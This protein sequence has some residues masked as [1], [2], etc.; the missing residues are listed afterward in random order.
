[1]FIPEMLRSDPNKI[2]SILDEMKIRQD[3]SYNASRSDLLPQP[4]S[5]IPIED[6]HLLNEAFENFTPGEYVGYE[7]DDPSM[8]QKEGDATFIYA[9]IIEEVN[10]EEN[11]TLFGKFFKINVGHDK[12]PRVVEFADLYKFHRLQSSSLGLS[13]EQETATQARD[14][15]KIFAE[16]SDV[17]EE[18]WRLPEERRRKIVKRLFLRWHPDKNLGDETFCTEAFQHIQNEITR[19]ER[20]ETR[21]G[22]PEN[23]RSSFETF[24]NHW[25]KRAK[26]HNAQR[27]E[28][29]ETF[30]RKYGTCES[31]SRKGDSWSCLPPS[32]CKKNP[33]PGE[34]KRWFRQAEADLAA[35]DNDLATEKPSYEWVCFKCHQVRT[36]FYACVFV[37]RCTKVG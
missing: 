13:D 23:H 32:F 17:L 25:R 28:Y 35:A 5:F 26:R 22:E 1:M 27:R 18:A 8:Q 30:I 24:F 15:K 4:G 37:L 21:E 20:G 34:A 36:S 12:E 11:S 16:I 31:T 2:W 33:Q 6:H 14:K 3:D 10:V 7:M 9:V 19:L 29:K